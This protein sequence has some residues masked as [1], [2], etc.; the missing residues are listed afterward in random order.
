MSVIT[1]SLFALLSLFASIADASFAIFV[2]RKNPK[3]AVNQLASLVMLC[4]VFW[5]LGEFIARMTQDYQ[6]AEITI[7]I[8]VIGVCLLPSFFLHFALQFT[9]RRDLLSQQWI[10]PT[11]YV[12]GIIFSVL[13]VAGYITKTIR[14]SWGFTATPS[15][16]YLPFILWLEAYFLIGLYFCYR[17]LASAKSRRERIQTLIVIFGATVPLVLGSLTHAF[18]PLFGIQTP[19]IAVVASTITA[20]TLTYGIVKFQL[21]SLTPETT[22]MNILNTMGDLLA[23]TDTRGYVVF[24]NEAFRRVLVGYGN[25]VGT[26][27]LRDFLVGVDSMLDG[28]LWNT[29]MRVPQSRL[30]EVDYRT[31]N[32]TTFPVLLTVSPVY[33]YDEL[34]GFVFL[35]RD[36]TEQK[37]LQHQLLEIARR[38]TE[39]LQHFAVSVQ[40]AQEEERRRIARELHDDLGQRL[41]G[42]KFAIDILED[43]IPQNKKKIIAKLRNIRNQIVEMITEIRRISSNLHPSVLDDFGL[44]I[45]LQL[46]CKEF[47]KVHALKTAFQTSGSI[48]E[49]FDPQAEIALY[50]I[51]Q[52]ALSNVAKHAQAT[53]VTVQ[54]SGEGNV[55][56]LSVKD[57]GKGFEMEKAR[58]MRNG[59]QGLGLVSMKERAELLG[60]T[61]GIESQRNYG[62]KIHVKIPLNFH[63][64]N[65]DTNRR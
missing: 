60:G 9:E 52:E 40:R 38:R 53:E 63:E 48:P 2:L 15:T 33:D 61:F 51:T 35:A 28:K 7:R 25:V 29:H 13:Q 47:E 22:A 36:I 59:D 10:Y 42:M 54:L 45:A 5:G 27:H 64:E 46:L 31:C 8:S 11:I 41:S 30:M 4:L 57:N 6:T 55:I 14:L 32:G 65:Q 24:T 37:H 3:S 43:A 26:F 34:I 20:G 21:M 44:V 12:P 39:D 62:T 49:H 17:K 16:G 1:I 19:R 50:R 23:V 18:F 56:A 58:T